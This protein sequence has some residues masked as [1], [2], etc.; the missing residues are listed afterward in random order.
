M[1]TKEQAIKIAQNEIEGKDMHLVTTTVDDLG[2]A[3]L[4][5]IESYEHQRFEMNKPYLTNPTELQEAMWRGE[6]L[7][8]DFPIEVSKNTG[9]ITFCGLSEEN[10]K[11]TLEHQRWFID[12][13]LAGRRTAI[14][15]FSKD[16]F[17]ASSIIYAQEKG[18]DVLESHGKILIAQK[19][20]ISDILSEEEM[21]VARKE[22]I[23]YMNPTRVEL[24]EEMYAKIKD[25]SIAEGLDAL[26]ARSRELKES[27]LGTME[28]NDSDGT[29]GILWYRVVF[30]NWDPLL[31]NSLK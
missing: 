10:Q 15:L 12:E 11:K 18:C 26:V 17:D 23:G 8:W 24:I 13:V 21:V 29:L 20:K 5:H 27:N 4:V 9:K 14:G 6:D 30:K 19:K 25:L 2:H 31:V 7:S 22:V 1:I 28:I 16:R 3:W